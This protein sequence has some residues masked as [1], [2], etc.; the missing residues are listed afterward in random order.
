MAYQTSDMHISAHERWEAGA[1][2]ASVPPVG[3]LPASAFSGVEPQNFTKR[4]ILTAITAEI[5][6]SRSIFIGVFPPPPFFLIV[7]LRNGNK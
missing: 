2:R 5:K 4:K 1:V 7:T 3:G 6:L